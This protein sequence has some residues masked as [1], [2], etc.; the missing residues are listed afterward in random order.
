MTD[1]HETHRLNVSIAHNVYDD[2]AVKTE[3]IYDGQT[4][5]AVVALA[6]PFIS[7]NEEA[8]RLYREAFRIG[9]QKSLNDIG[10][11]SS[12]IEER[13]EDRHD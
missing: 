1:M 11:G 9:F 13:R 2:G 12:F 6:P 3:I 7:Q 4:A 10:F 5:S 8:F